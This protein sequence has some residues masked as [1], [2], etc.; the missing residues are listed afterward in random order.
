MAW[1][2]P[3]THA[4]SD[5]IT[6][7]ML[8]QELRDNLNETA[9]GI[10][11]A[12]GRLIVTDGANS[13]VERIVTRDLDTDT[14]VFTDTSYTTFANLTGTPASGEVEVAVVTGT[15]AIV[16]LYGRISNS[17]AGSSTVLGFSVSGATTVATDS[18]RSMTYESGAA[19]DLFRGSAVIMLVALTAGTNTFTLEARVTAGTGTLQDATVFVLPL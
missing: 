2:D 4:G 7:A 15:A 18:A 14:L 19:N 11:S 17:N 3:K 9:A 10:A 16:F 8:N 1:S 5:D 13:L 12:A 6:A